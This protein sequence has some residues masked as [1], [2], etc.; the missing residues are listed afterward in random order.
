MPK[1]PSTLAVVKEWIGHC[2]EKHG[3]AQGS[4]MPTRLLEIRRDGQE[5][6][7]C[8]SS[9][10]IQAYAALSYRWGS[11]KQK[12]LGVDT[13]EE[14]RTGL[15]TQDLPQTFQD[16]IWV[17]RQLGIR[18]LWVDSLCIVQ[19]DPMDWIAHSASMIEV[20]GNATLTISA[21]RANDSA[22]GFLSER[23][24]TYVRLPVELDGV[25]GKA[26][27]FPLPIRQVG[28][29]EHGMELELSLIHI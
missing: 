15:A 28:H 19:D 27:G 14:F 26:Y 2:I 10:E 21:S 20:Y 11:T 13:I 16:A 8:D 7:L 5:L 25:S 3:H 18:F 29:P 12:T 1:D 6:V 22:E 9:T 4:A 23:L 24:R 17:C